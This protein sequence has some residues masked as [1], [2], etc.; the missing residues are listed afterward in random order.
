LKALDE[1]ACKQKDTSLPPACA[2]GPDHSDVLVQLKLKGVIAADSPEGASGAGALR[3]VTRITNAGS[4]GPFPSG[5][6][7]FVDLPHEIP[8]TLEEGKTGLKT[9][10]DA[11]L[12]SVGE[13]DLGPCTSV[14]IMDVVILDENG[15][16][17]ARPCLFLP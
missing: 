11:L 12:N 16:E 14:E 15:D 17:F 1:P 10:Y 2:V 5:A 6:A 7:T 8:F 9:S 3:L 4:A 13:T